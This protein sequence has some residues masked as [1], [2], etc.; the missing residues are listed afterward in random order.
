MLRPVALDLNAMLES[1]APVLRRIVGEMVSLE[2]ELGP[3]LP[4]VLADRGALEQVVLNL[5]LNARDAMPGQGRL[6]VATGEV[7]V[8]ETEASQ[9]EE[10]VRPGRYGVLSVSDTGIGIDDRTRARL[11]EPFWRGER[12][13]TRND[14][15]TGLGLTIA[16]EVVQRLG[17]S[18]VAATRPQVEGLRFTI[19]LAA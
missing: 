10:P 12:A 6:R 9:R 19:T 14:G 1:F 3:R 2:L 13:D 18:I 15:G 16:R 7:V 4:P 11:F 5:T 17:G 8:P